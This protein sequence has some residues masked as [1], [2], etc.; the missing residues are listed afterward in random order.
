MQW[1]MIGIFQQI[2]RRIRMFSGIVEA[3]GVINRIVRH[4]DC[5]GF[6]ITPSKVF[7]D[8]NVGDSVAING[9][10]L[11]VTEL[12]ANSFA[13]TVVPQT[14][15]ITNLGLLNE[16]SQINLERSLCANAR[17]G[18][19]YVQGHV[20]ATGEIIELTSDGSD[21]LLVKIS[22][23]LELQKYVVNKG[24]IALD[25]MSITVIEAS[26]TWVKVTFIPHTQ[27]VTVVN[28]YQ[29]G[30]KINIE[31]DILGKYVEKIVGVQQ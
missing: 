6:T 13:V 3:L 21:A 4:N 1:V 23:P 12:F 31:V 14:L 2:S 27:Q 29:I 30:S 18:G 11:T 15:R 10:C 19:H 7:D 8:L 24:Y 25:G 17:I 22:L 16:G 9:V 20:D 26:A 28:Q 5:V